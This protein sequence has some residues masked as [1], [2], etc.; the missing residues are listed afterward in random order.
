MAGTARGAA[1]RD[2]YS[3]FEQAYAMGVNIAFGTDVGI[4][5]HGQNA[6]EFAIMVELGMSEADAIRSATVATAEL[7]GLGDDRGVIK[8]GKR[9]DIIAV[10]ENPLENIEALKNVSFVMKSGAVV[11]QNGDYLGSIDTRP[12]LGSPVKF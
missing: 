4:F 6:R 3:S 10:H 9:A 11:K 1:E 12:V 2:E 5:D 8:P 7:F